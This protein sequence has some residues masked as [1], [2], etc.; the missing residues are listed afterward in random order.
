MM[1]PCQASWL[2]VKDE[3]SIVSR[4]SANDQYSIIGM[5]VNVDGSCGTRPNDAANGVAETAKGLS[6][7]A[8]S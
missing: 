2:E 3:S 8:R 4:R 6:G 1:L 5:C 7:W